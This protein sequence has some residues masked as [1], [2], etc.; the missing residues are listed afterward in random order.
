MPVLSGPD[1]RQIPTPDIPDFPLQ[2]VSS[3]SRAATVSRL[4]S[5]VV[6]KIM[7]LGTGETDSC[8]HDDRF[9]G[10]F[11]LPK[12]CGGCLACWSEKLAKRCDHLESLLAKTW[13]YCR[14]NKLRY[15]TRIYC[16][17]TEIREKP[18]G[19]KR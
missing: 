11:D 1:F 17:M 13:D 14:D 10:V 9:S 4:R 8:E 15:R 7:S 5:Q 19:Q 2:V 3:P 18:D 16:I 12:D 6:L